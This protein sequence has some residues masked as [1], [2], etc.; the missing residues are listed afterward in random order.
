MSGS[1]CG[2]EEAFELQVEKV[3]AHAVDHGHTGIQ[4][5]GPQH[6]CQGTPRCDCSQLTCDYLT[7]QQARVKACRY[8]AE[9]TAAALCMPCLVVIQ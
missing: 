4:H 7:P 8:A 5:H 6:Q 2:Y 1:M 9:A 3:R